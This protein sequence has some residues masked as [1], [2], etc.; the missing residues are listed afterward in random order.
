MNFEKLH[1]CRA[2]LFDYGGTLDSGGEHWLDRFFL[3]YEDAYL[4]VPRSEIKR[5]FYHADDV[6]YVDK[7][8]AT[9]GL[10]ALMEFHVHLQFEALSLVDSGKEKELVD[11][12]CAK[13]EKFHRLAGRLLSR[14]KPR[15]RLGV[16]SNFYGNL[17]SLLKEAEL[18]GLL[19][20]I[21]DSKHVG[22]R[23]PD[24]G[25]FRFALERLDLSPEQVIFVGDSYERDMVP[26][27]ELGM[28]T[29][30][31]KSSHSSASATARVDACISSLSQ[32]EA[33][34]L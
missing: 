15:Y 1:K 34:I 28:K 12:F 13:S 32:L 2:I 5:A 19:D 16:V 33:L 22:V 14:M 21:A 29:V 31:L 7:R 27:G 25:I 6:C 24:P 17:A 8:V 20:V 4:H 23:K 10:R 9:L 26:G 30:W 18:L 3:L 11:K